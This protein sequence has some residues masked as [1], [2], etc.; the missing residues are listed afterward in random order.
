MEAAEPVLEAKETEERTPQENPSPCL[1]ERHLRSKPLMRQV[2]IQLTP[3]QLSSD[4]E[5][6]RKRHLAQKRLLEQFSNSEMCSSDE[7][8]AKKVCDHHALGSQNSEEAA[9]RG[10]SPGRAPV[11]SEDSS[12]SDSEDPENV[13]KDY[14]DGSPELSAYERKRLKNI[15][16]NAR[17]FASLKM[18][19]TAARL[20]EITTKGRSCE[21]K[22][23]RPPKSEPATACRRSMRL[24]RVDP[25]GLPLPEPQAQPEPVEEHPRLPPGLL[26][27]VPA[28][29][30]QGAERTKGFLEMW[31][32]I[33]QVEPKEEER[34]TCTLESYQSSLRR[35]VLSRDSVA[36]VVR[37]RI[38]SVAVHPSESKTLV[39]A[40][41]KWGQIGLW[42]LECGSEDGIH[43]F[44]THS[45]PV[46]CIGF[47]PSNPAQLF[48]LSHD[49]TIRCGDVTR[50]TFE[51]VYRNE[52]Q[53]LSSFDFLAS[54][55]STL[56]VGMWDG[57]VAVVDRRTPET[58]SELSA[59]LDSLTRTVHVH[60][61]NRH[62]FVIA[63][64]RNVGIYDVRHLKMRGNKPV[65]SLAG[66]TK[67]VASAYFSPVTGNR[68]LT[69]CADDTLRIFGTKCLSSLAPALTTIRHNN[70]TGRWLTRFRAVWDPKREDCFVVGSM[71]RPRRIE[72]F[73][74]NGEMLQAFLSE[75]HLGSVCSINAWHPSRY[76]LVGGNSSGRLHVFKE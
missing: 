25:T 73:R 64:A 18:F 45:R 13:G 17:F 34:I 4:G 48:S 59:D 51:E 31:A 14:E 21:R 57:I 39:A 66:H 35:M 8:T 60:P 5:G 46:S 12:S 40:G 1:L 44:V 10:E 22:R 71:S 37:D 33:S 49:G 68:V 67:S 19:E 16:E 6:E 7:P 26:P 54:D 32:K 53:S 62:Y 58:S 29:Q 65:V 69:T 9:F 41:D 11:A 27:M 38:Y 76:I 75:D 24:Q 52:E 43:T 61:V 74:A 72:A 55:A 15:T 2:R 28:D 36:K 56:L 20:R 63:G 70:N 3:V 30:E 42:D 50:A 23:V 47:S